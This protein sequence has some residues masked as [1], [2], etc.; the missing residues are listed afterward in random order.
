M[1]ETLQTDNC[2]LMSQRG[3]VIAQWLLQGT[4]KKTKL[5]EFL[6]VFGHLCGTRDQINVTLTLFSWTNWAELWGTKHLRS[7]SLHMK[8][9]K[10]QHMLKHG[11]LCENETNVQ[12]AR[13]LQPNIQD[14]SRLANIVNSYLLLKIIWPLERPLWRSKSEPHT[15]AWSCS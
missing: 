11:R 14:W 2:Y 3:S 15:A 10:F 8:L 4:K 7:K 9:W 6:C 5:A 1:S 12:V 13:S